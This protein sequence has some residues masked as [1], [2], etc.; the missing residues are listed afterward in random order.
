MPVVGPLGGKNSKTEAKI[1]KMQSINNYLKKHNISKLD[2]A[3]THN[4]QYF[5]ADLTLVGAKNITQL[6][7]CLKALN[8]KISD[9]HITNILNMI[10]E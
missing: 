2:L 10:N 6:D 8:S 5:A 4:L 9:Q 3:F 1:L 7:Q